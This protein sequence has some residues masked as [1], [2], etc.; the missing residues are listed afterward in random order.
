MPVRRR[1]RLT[2]LVPS[3]A[4]LTNASRT[5]T[6]RARSRTW[7]RTTCAAGGARPAAGETL[8]IVSIGRPVGAPAGAEPS[9]AARRDAGRRRPGSGRFRRHRLRHHALRRAQQERRGEGQPCPRMC[10]RP[11]QTPLLC[12]RRSTR[13]VEALSSHGMEHLSRLWRCGAAGRPARPPRRAVCAY[14]TS[15]GSA[16]RAPAASRRAAPPAGRARPRGRSPT[17]CPTRRRPP[18]RRRRRR[19]RRGCA[20]GR[21][22]VTTVTSEHRLP[23]RGRCRAAARRP[24]RRPRCAP[25]DAA[26]IAPNSP[27]VT[28]VKPA[29]ARPAP[30]LLRPAQLSPRRSGPGPITAA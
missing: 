3:P 19:P 27:P 16:R 7:K 10:Q 9:G 8:K 24:S 5:R 21:C 1:P 11:C 23:A 13:C 14:A 29:A 18:R 4:R 15:L 20:R 25:R 6:R 17:A 12:C 22:P 28:S 26:S 2:R 30:D